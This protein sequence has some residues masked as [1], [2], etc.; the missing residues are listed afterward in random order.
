MTYEVYCDRQQIIQ[1]FWLCLHWMFNIKKHVSQLWHLAVLVTESAVLFSYGSRL[2]WFV[3]TD[4]LCPVCFV[5]KL[6]TALLQ[7][8]LRFGGCMVLAF[9]WC[10]MAFLV[11]LWS[12]VGT[13]SNCLQIKLQHKLQKAQLDKDNT[14][15]PGHRYYIDVFESSVSCRS[16]NAS[17][18]V[19]GAE[20]F[21]SK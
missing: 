14:R 2:S 5:F 6:Q 8:T 12:L 16:T 19:Y 20:I 18:K 10:G 21:S 1:F 11:C 3:C 13:H 7:A 17:K 15:G 4:L 9:F